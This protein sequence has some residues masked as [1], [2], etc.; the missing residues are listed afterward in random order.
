MSKRIHRLKITSEYFEAIESGEKTFEIRYN[1]RGY[2]K[3]DLVHLKPYEGACYVQPY[4][5][6][7]REITY[8]I[9]YQQKENWVVFSMKPWKAKK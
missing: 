4:E 1:D 8:V 3:G 9:G 5:G 6:L 2:Q 7:W